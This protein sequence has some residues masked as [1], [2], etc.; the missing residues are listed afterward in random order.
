MKSE[1]LQFALRST[2]QLATEQL[3]VLVTVIGMLKPSTRETAE[4]QTYVGE[5]MGTQRTIIVVL[6][7]SPKR[8]L[9]DS[10]GWN[11]LYIAYVNNVVGC[12]DASL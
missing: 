6:A 8:E 11:A 7:V 12:S 1:R 2:G 10:R 3:T 5:L 4:C 9:G